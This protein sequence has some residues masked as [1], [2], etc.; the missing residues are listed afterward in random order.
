MQISRNGQSIFC[1]LI[2]FFY[3]CFL[4]IL[5]KTF[6]N[7]NFIQPCFFFLISFYWPKKSWYNEIILYFLP[8][9]SK[10]QDFV[11]CFPRYV[12]P[13]YLEDWLNILTPHLS[14]HPHYTMCCT[15]LSLVNIKSKISSSLLQQ[16]LFKM[17]LNLLHT[18]I[19]VV[20]AP[21]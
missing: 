9:V 6:L 20:L 13:T 10:S 12:G 2:L 4:I 16:H 18:T 14:A 19:V 3:L 21:N 17:V 11:C 5:I 15:K 1:V 8:E 7:L